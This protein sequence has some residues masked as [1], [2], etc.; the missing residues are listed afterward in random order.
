ML[1]HELVTYIFR[2]SYRQHVCNFMIRSFDKN[3]QEWNVVRYESRIHETGQIL[4]TNR[5]EIFINAVPRFQSLVTTAH[6]QH[7]LVILHGQ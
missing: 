7:V 1:L 4:F 3:N 5:T 6:P 2:F